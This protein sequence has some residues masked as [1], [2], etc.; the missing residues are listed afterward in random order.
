MKK[1]LYIFSKNL[2]DYGIKQRENSWFNL[3]KYEDRK[4]QEKEDK[5]CKDLMNKEL[6]KTGNS[7]I[8]KKE[9]KK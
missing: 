8:R 7:L 2:D 4:I 3:G 1:S 6:I 9:N 5:I